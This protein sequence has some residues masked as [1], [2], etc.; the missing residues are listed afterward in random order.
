MSRL[1][2]DRHGTL[3]R[4]RLLGFYPAVMENGVRKSAYKRYC[5]D[6]MSNVLGA[7]KTDW[8]PRNPLGNTDLEPGCNSCRAE[9]SDPEQ[10][11][12]FYATAWIRSDSRVDYE[13]QYCK[14]CADMLIHEFDMKVRNA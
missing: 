12:Y 1:P 2:C 4:G 6:C 13:A 7:H 9:F 3:S 8:T 5:L 11:R 14:D 10:I